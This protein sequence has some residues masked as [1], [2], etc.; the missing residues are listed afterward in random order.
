[1][2]SGIQL[3]KCVAMQAEDMSSKSDISEVKLSVRVRPNA[4]STCS[5]AA[6]ATRISDNFDTKKVAALE[7]FTFTNRCVEVQ[8]EAENVT[9]QGVTVQAMCYYAGA[10]DDESP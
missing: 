10:N 4:G 8:I 2:P 3:V 7:G 9:A 1:M 5:G 6:T